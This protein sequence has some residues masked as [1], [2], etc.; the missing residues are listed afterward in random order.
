MPVERKRLEGLGATVFEKEGHDG[1]KTLTWMAK[2]T[3]E[4]SGKEFETEVSRSLGDRHWKPHGMIGM[5]TVDIIN[6]ADL[7]L[8]D[9]DELFAIIVTD[10]ILDNI[11]EEEVVRHLA[12]S[13]YRSPKDYRESGFKV[14]SPLRACE[15]LVRKSSIMWESRGIDYR[16]D[17]TIGVSK[18]VV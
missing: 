18:I 8:S 16:N 17:M 3:D 15:E 12:A 1:A 14:P 5:P 13:L 7:K 6:V 2:F 9:N 11:P 4:R 10:G